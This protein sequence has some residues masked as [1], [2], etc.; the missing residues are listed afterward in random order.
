M[1]W[2]ALVDNRQRFFWVLQIAGWIGYALVNYIGSKVFEMRDIYVFVI[3]LNAYAGCLMTVPLRYLYRKVWN[4]KPLLLIFVVFSTSYLTGTLWSVVQKFNM[5]EIYRHGY[6]PEEW[7]Y[8]LQQGLDSVYIILCWSGLYFGIKY[9]QLLQ[10]ERQK[11]LKANTMAHEAQLKMLRYQLNPHFLFNTLNAISTLVLVEENKDA[12]QMVSRLSDFL[13]YTLNT[14][15]IKKVPLEQELHALKLY[16]NIE[17]V[18]FD[19]RLE[20][21][22]DI[23][24]EAK[25][26]LV[27]SLIMQP[28]IENSIKYAIAHMA[29]GGKIEIR[30][31]VFAN[32]LLL[33]VGD[34]GPGAS[35]ENGQLSNVQGVGIAN[36]QD[37]LRTL[38]ENNYSFVLAHNTPS[39]LKVNIRVPF[40]KAEK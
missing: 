15:P 33:E 21:V 18:R 26:A 28:L 9:Y 34:N 36:T 4:A 22:F 17:K 29:S 13:R 37:R 7:Y 40:E 25:Q 38:Y 16:L 35:I 1:K 31:Q 32:E 3:V 8:Y 39:G 11:A 12:N 6:R 27:P 19:E 23:T 30:A 24:E 5:W 20:V 14:D 10:S 2:Q